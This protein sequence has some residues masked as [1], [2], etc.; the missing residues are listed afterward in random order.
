MPAEGAVISAGTLSDEATDDLSDVVT[1]FGYGIGS[2]LVTEL[3]PGIKF[4]EVGDGVSTGVGVG[5]GA[6]GE[7]GGA[8]GVA[9]G[10]AGDVA[11]ATVRTPLPQTSFDPDF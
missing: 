2:D 4:F 6:I 9:V 5:V 3:I 8:E 7:G 10:F 11:A 1:V